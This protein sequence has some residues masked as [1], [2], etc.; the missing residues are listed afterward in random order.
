MDNVLSITPIY[1][2]SQQSVTIKL[3]PQQFYI[4]AMIAE[5]QHRTIEEL[6]AMLMFDGFMGFRYVVDYY[7][8][9]REEDKKTNK[10]IEGYTHEEQDEIFKLL[11]FQQR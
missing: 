9:K 2:Q 8:R 3:T 4:L 7:V 10:E 6:A 5:D 11:V 1:E